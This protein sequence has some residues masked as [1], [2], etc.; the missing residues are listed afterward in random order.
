MAVKASNQIDLIDLTDGY[1]VILTS[2]SHTFIGGTSSVSGTQTAMTQ[3]MAFRGDDPI[4]CTVGPIAGLPEGLSAVNGGQ[5]PAPIITF[6]ATSALAAKGTVNIAV[7]IGGLT[8]NKVWSY[9]IAFRGTDGQNGTSVTITSTSVQYQA[10]PS[11][12]VTPT[13]AWNNA[14]PS[15]TQGQYLWTRTIVNYSDSKSTTSYSV[16]RAG[17]DGSAGSSV[18]VSQTSVTYQ[19]SASGTVTP[20][21]A[22][23][24]SP[25]AVTQGQYLWT[26][27]YVKY[28]DNKETTS[29]S[30]S[31][32]GV[33]GSDGDDA[34]ILSITSS[35]GTIFKNTAVATTLTAHV[36]KGGV[37]VTGTS[38]TALGTIKWYKNSGATAVATGASLT[39]TAG[40][41][42][43]KATYTA[44]LES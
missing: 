24:A 1:S 7:I 17:T 36:F 19:A 29:Y 18:T 30:V 28:S 32:S 9:A 4:A 14:I 10:S 8:I 43:D 31:R 20:T 25:P 33:D 26:K 44:Q 5:S 22:W 41:V 37:E 35:G 40:D 27:T 13:G 39:V 6:T 38:L 42:T 34:I 11:G 2:D 15:L 23:L 21:G 3:V 12:T 16:S